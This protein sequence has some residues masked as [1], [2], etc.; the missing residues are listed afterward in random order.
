MKTMR[1]GQSIINWDRYDGWKDQKNLLITIKWEGSYQLG[2]AGVVQFSLSLK[3][4][5]SR[6]LKVFNQMSDIKLNILLISVCYFEFYSM[7]AF[8][9]VQCS[10]E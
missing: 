4:C 10:V 6:A 2:E 5:V 9:Q 1:Q 3:L 8:F 7:S